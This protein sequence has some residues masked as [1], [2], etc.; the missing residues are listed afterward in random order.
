MR[1]IKFRAWDGE[2]MNYNVA[3]IDGIAYKREYFATIWHPNAK[4]G[5]PM[6]YTGFKD[7]NGKEI[8]EGDVVVGKCQS[9]WYDGYFNVKGIVKYDDSKAVFLVEGISDMY[10][11]YLFEIEDL[12]V[13]GNI[14]EDPELLE[15]VE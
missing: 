2:K 1:E 13:I 14:Y 10:G 15:C 6:Q 8:Y 7:K 11:G 9:H 5:V 12:E 3:L 4:A